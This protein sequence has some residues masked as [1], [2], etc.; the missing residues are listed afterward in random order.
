MYLF[1]HPLSLACLLL[2]LVRLKECGLV[3]QSLGL[4]WPLSE[5]GTGLEKQICS[6]PTR[7]VI[8]ACL[9]GLETENTSSSSSSYQSL[10]RWYCLW[11]FC[12][13]SDT[14]LLISVSSSLQYSQPNAIP[15]IIPCLNLLYISTIPCHVTRIDEAYIVPRVN[16]AHPTTKPLNVNKYAWSWSYRY[17]LRVVLVIVSVHCFFCHGGSSGLAL[18]S[19][20]IIRSIFLGSPLGFLWYHHTTVVFQ[21]ILIFVIPYGKWFKKRCNGSGWCIGLVGSLWKN[22]IQLVNHFY[23]IFNSRSSTTPII[24]QWL[25]FHVNVFKH[26][27]LGPCQWQNSNSWKIIYVLFLVLC[28]YIGIFITAIIENPITIILVGLHVDFNIIHN[29]LQLKQCLPE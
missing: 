5:G 7:L 23:W 6:I 16:N 13:H 14:V 27:T 26:H 20:M 24:F 22:G 8:Q 25:K 4:D 12:L 3:T 9:P 29:V 18:V 17:K 19:K 21:T 11:Y 10:T 2:R 28:K 15:N 1:I